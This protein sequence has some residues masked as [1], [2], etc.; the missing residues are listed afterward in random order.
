MFNSFLITLTFLSIFPAPQKFL[1]EWNEKNLRYFC[2]MI[3]VTG[4]LFALCW[5]SFFYALGLAEKFSEILR[6]FLMTFL[7]LSLTGGLH[8]DGLM[9]TCDAVFSRRDMETR[10]KIL[11]D[12]HAGS[13]AVIGCVLIL[14]AKTFLFA[15]IF[16]NKININFFI[17]VYSRLGM[18]VILNNINFAKSGGLAFIMGAARK[19]SDNIFFVI[20]FLFLSFINNSLIIP[21]IF[22]FSLIIWIK[23]CLKIFGGIT[24][25]LLGAF[26]EISEI[27]F[28][29]GTVIENCI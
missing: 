10:L 15:E 1:P 18:A 22:I 19:K 8:M 3:P 27:L 23:I 12:T 24:G 6:G 20:I 7:T 21:L 9:D 26:L 29:I 11:S 13:F 14:M 16:S 28:L 17:P 5:G 25:D 4:F 2:L